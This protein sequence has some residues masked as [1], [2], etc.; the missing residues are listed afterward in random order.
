M[1]Q[2]VLD[3]EGVLVPPV[4]AR[5]L[6]EGFCQLEALANVLGGDKVLRHFDGR[7]DVEDLARR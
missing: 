3:P 7:T 6:A 2:D 1:Q 4:A 5:Q